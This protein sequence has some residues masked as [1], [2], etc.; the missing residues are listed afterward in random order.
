M[1]C[2]RKLQFDLN[3]QIKETSQNVLERM[4]RKDATSLDWPRVFCT[5]TQAGLVTLEEILCH[6]ASLYDESIH[7]LTH[8]H[9][10]S[11]RCTLYHPHI[12]CTNG[13]YKIYF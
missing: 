9:S 8:S 11:R 7:G 6:Q 2:F 10:T 3:L 1:G 4:T 12:A 13:P 5:L